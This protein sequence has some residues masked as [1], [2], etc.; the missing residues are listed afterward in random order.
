MSIEK[1]TPGIADPLTKA[2]TPGVNKL[3][4]TAETMVESGG[5]KLENTLKCLAKA[6]QPLVTDSKLPSGYSEFVATRIKK[7]AT[8]QEAVKDANDIFGLIEH[9]AKS[10]EESAKVFIKNG[11]TDME[12]VMDDFTNG[13]KKAIANSPYKTVEAYE[14]QTNTKIASMTPE[15]LSDTLNSLYHYIPR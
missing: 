15:E 12:K 3:T 9:T 14:A 4:Q 13:I 11:K 5:Q 10:A 1:I 2:I 7:G 6:N 8:V